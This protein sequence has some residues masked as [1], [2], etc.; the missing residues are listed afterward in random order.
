MTLTIMPHGIG[1]FEWQVV[2]REIAALSPLAVYLEIGSMEGGSL[3]AFGRLFAPGNALIAVDRP[4][5]HTRPKLEAVATKMR[6]LGYDIHLIIGSSHN[7]AIASAVDAALAGRTVD[8]LF[9]DGDHSAEGVRADVADY[10]PLV[11]PG[12]LVVMHDVGPMMGR[13]GPGP[14]NITN[15]SAAWCYLAARHKRK[16]IVQ[17]GAGYGMVWLDRTE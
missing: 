2:S 16:L 8:V 9:I 13:H 17:Q 4:I 7:S 5:R 1:E 10:V 11:R 3:W 12:G 14:E 15:C 6:R